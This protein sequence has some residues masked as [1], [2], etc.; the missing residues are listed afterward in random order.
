M[1]YSNTGIEYGKKGYLRF[2]TILW[3]AMAIVSILGAFLSLWLRWVPDKAA[4]FGIAL[5]LVFGIVG[6]YFL[7]RYRLRKFQDG[8]E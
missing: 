4:L 2:M 6:N 7:G 1:V 8:E 5:G 3:F